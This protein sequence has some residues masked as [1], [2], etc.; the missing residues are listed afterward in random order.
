[1]P[2]LEETIQAFRNVAYAR[3]GIVRVKISSAASL[4]PEERQISASAVQ[5]ADAR[6][7]RNWN[8]ILMAA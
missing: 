5:R 3:L 1:M 8:S 6:S 4:S 7:N 2:L